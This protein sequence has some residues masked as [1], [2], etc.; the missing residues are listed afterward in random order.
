MQLP[1]IL[2]GYLKRIEMDF[3]SAHQIGAGNAAEVVHEV[4]IPHVRVA[5][6]KCVAIFRETR[7]D[8]PISLG[9]EKIGDRYAFGGPRRPASAAA[10]ATRRAT[11]PT[12][13]DAGSVALCFVSTRAGARTPTK[14]PALR[15]RG[16][17]RT[18]L[19]ALRAEAL[20]VLL[21]G[22]SVLMSFPRKRE[23]RNLEKP[24]FPL[25]RE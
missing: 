20:P 3:G 16:G 15:L 14:H 25:S 21:Q 13:T 19:S 5:S 10:C 7:R 17:R 12:V 2:K 1:K 23:P 6:I 11:A 22:S 8:I 18:S 24:G 9:S 4:D